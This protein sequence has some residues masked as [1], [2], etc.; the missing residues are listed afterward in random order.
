MSSYALGAWAHANEPASS[1]AV[2]AT[3]FNDFIV[4]SSFVQ[5]LENRSRF[6]FRE[7]GAY[8]HVLHDRCGATRIHRRNLGMAACAIRLVHLVRREPF[9]HCGLRRRRSR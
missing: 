2:P 6:L 1:T 5:V 8:A 9:L 3:A 7:V 4:V